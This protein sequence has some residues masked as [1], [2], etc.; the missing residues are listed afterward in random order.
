MFLRQVIEKKALVQWKPDAR[1]LIF[2]VGFLLGGSSVGIQLLLDDTRPLLFFLLL[3]LSLFNSFLNKSYKWLE[4][5][6]GQVR[7]G[8][9]EKE[10]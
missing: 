3:S 5:I 8:T 4:G 9:K 7:K 1:G 10:K 6:N 2:L